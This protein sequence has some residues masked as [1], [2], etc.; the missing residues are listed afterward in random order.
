MKKIVLL[1]APFSSRS[2]YGD[3]ARD[4]FEALHLSDKYDLK[5][6]DVP[7]GDCPM[8]AL[9][10]DNPVHS[11][12]KESMLTPDNPLN[13][14]PD[15]YIDIRIPNEFEQH[16]KYNIG[17]TAGIETTGVSHKWVEGCN[18][19]DMIIV[20]SFHS[21]KT[22]TSVV[23][24]KMQNTPDGKQTKI[25]ELKVEKP[26]EVIFEGVDDDVYK[27][28]NKD[29]ISEEFF[30][31]LNNEVPEK[32]AFLFVGQ[33]TGGPKTKFGEDRKDIAKL[34]KV[35]YESF[36]NKKKQPALI[37]KTNGATYSIMDREEILYKMKEI[38][39]MF[40][41]DWKLPNVYLLHGDF[42]KKEMNELYNHPKVKAMVSF[43]H[44][45]GF[46]RPLLEATMVGLPVIASNWS[47]QIDFLS[48]E[49]SA[50][51]N[52][53]LDLV[54]KSAVWKDI[55]IPESSWFYIYEN[56]AYKILN[57]AFKDYDTFKAGT[58]KLMD[59]NREKYT[60]KNMSSILLSVIERATKEQPQQVNITLPKLKK[61]GDSDAP[62]SDIKLPKLKKAT[63]SEVTGG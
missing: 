57:N 56:E 8:N 21:K 35:F 22:F 14:Q 18:K 41:S 51:I 7:W 27:P 62:T 16:G 47:G 33:W 63:V 30:E 12:I 29:E 39:K 55:I 6:I 25:G 32:F 1:C 9:S 61:L 59:K 5:I 11:A 58:K 38:K 17:I 44:G 42:D 36:A 54:P 24:D 31:W 10:L 52:G 23:Y 34:I 48:K 43:T 46:G 4:L 50:L 40:P 26:I 15:I 28:L 60:I 49:H 19:M 53:Q 3:H 45:E 2:G 20:P 13:Q 37:L